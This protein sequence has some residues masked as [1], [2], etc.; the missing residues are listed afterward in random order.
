MIYNKSKSVLGI[1][2]SEFSVVMRVPT[3]LRTLRA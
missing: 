3:V 1:A 2:L